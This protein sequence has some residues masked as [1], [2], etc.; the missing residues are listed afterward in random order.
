MTYNK[1]HED[2]LTTLLMP[3]LSKGQCRVVL[4]S[5]E[6]HPRTGE[7]SSQVNKDVLAKLDTI[8]IQ[9]EQASTPLTEVQRALMSLHECLGHADMPTLQQRAKGNKFPTEPASI[10]N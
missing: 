4:P 3:N 6:T 9:A 10:K 2:E 8:K 5:E 1:G 7:L